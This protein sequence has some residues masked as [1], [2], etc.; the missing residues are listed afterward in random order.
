MLIRYGLERLKSVEGLRLFGPSTEE[1]RVAVFSFELSGVH[2]H[3]IATVLDA[4]GIAV[5]AG[6]HCA[7]VLM[8]CLGVPATTRASCYVYNTT[9]EIDR[10]VDGL[11][12]VREYF[13]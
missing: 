7:Q 4:Q 13:G 1:G 3:D 8:R 2:P 10:L 12:K 11:A 5:R 6:H 9:E